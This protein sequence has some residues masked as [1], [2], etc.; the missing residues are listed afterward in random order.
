M[1]EL[2]RQ[3]QQLQIQGSSKE[4]VAGL[5]STVQ[6][7]TDRLLKAEADMRVDLHSLSGQLSALQ[8]SLEDTNYRLAQLSQQIAAANQDLK[9]VRSATAPL[10]SLDAGAAGT[11][12]DPETLY[13]NAYSDYLRGAY[14]LALLGFRQYLESYS[15]T[16][17]ADNAVYWIGECFYRQQRFAEAIVEYDRVLER[18]PRS[19]KTASALLKKGYAQVELGQR[20]DGIAQLDKVVRSFPNSD[21]ANLARQKLQSLGVDSRTPR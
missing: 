9:A 17:L 14:D 19:D 5:K 7:Q 3:V 6:Q 10:G 12:A 13:Q 21:E 20:R 8:G 18:W 2:Q 1:T 15:E 16:D 11:S 4:E